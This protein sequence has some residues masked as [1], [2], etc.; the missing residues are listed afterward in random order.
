[1]NESDGFVDV[2]CCYR[3]GEPHFGVRFG[4]ANHALELARGGRDP[5]LRGADVFAEFAHRDVGFY[6]GF[7]GGRGDGG[8]A[9]VAGVGDVGG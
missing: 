8:V 9:G 2:V 6:E 4:E 1:M 5:A 3:L 7:G